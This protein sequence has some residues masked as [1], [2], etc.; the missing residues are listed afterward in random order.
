MLTKLQAKWFHTSTGSHIATIG[1]DLRCRIWAEDHSQPPNSGRRFKR[2]AQISSAVRTPFVSLDIKNINIVYTYL[3]LMDRQGLLTIYEPSNPD[4]FK[5]WNII[6]KWN[7]VI[8]APGR[9]QETSFRVRFDPNPQP[10]PWMNGLSDDSKMLSLVVTAMNTVKIYRSVISDS[11]GDNTALGGIKSFTFW[12]AAQLEAHP[13]LV[14]DVQW[15]PFNA[16]STDL[17]ATACKDGSVRIYEM[18]ITANTITKSTE[19]VDSARKQSHSAQSQPKSSLTTAIAGRKAA[20]QD[21]SSNN[22]DPS[23]NA[24]NQANVSRQGYS[25]PYKHEI[26]LAAKLESAHNDAWAVSWDPSGQV[27]MSGGAD[28]VTKLWKKS[29]ANEQWQ[30]FA[31]QAVEINDES[32]DGR[33]E[34]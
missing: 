22:I 8:P 25:F 28:G 2:I 7:V 20:S 14:R 11:N 27:L 24:S 1:N 6:D 17:I 26:A 31:D 4:D 19:E 3:A 12:E 23:L 9:G 32:E 21:L 33:A 10:L 5:E 15:A 18:D 29:I 34:G 16:R 30:L 13:N